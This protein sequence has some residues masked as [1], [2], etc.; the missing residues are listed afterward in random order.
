M[1]ELLHSIM[2]SCAH[3]ARLPS[4]KV[5][6]QIIYVL[7]RERTHF[8]EFAITVAMSAEAMK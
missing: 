2:R 5:L 6:V 7:I 4:A 1:R 8:G 3:K